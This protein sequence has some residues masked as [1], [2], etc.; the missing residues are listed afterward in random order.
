MEC[1]YIFVRGVARP[2]T[3]WK[4]KRQGVRG[5]PRPPVIPG[6]SPGRGTRGGGGVQASRTKTDFSQLEALSDAFLEAF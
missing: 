3:M 1:E 5:P 2:I 4:H 6:Q